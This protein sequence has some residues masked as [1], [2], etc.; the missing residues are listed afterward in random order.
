M[1]LLLD[2]DGTVIDS[3]EAI[4]ESFT[5]TCKKH[6]FPPPPKEEITALIG[7]PLDVMFER[8]GV[9]QEVVWD[10]VTSYK[11][12]YRVISKEKT[13]LLPNAKKAIQIA[14]TFATL[15]VVTTKTGEYS[16]EL[17]EHF[18]IMQHFVTLIG[19]EHV[20][21]P[22]PHPEPIITALKQIQ[23]KKNERVYMIGDTVLDLECAK[24]AGVEAVGV[25]SGYGKKSALELFGYP[26]VEDLLKSVLLLQK[27][28]K[29]H[30]KW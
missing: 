2:L 19:R 4:V 25:L 7:F 14:S 1:I 29:Q 22:K 11:E 28:K 10:F 5:L 8:V 6:N 23:P 27:E 18:G 13:F 21:N 26:I 24:N 17:L 12:H 15:G 16:V 30:T 3:T 20:K 9:L